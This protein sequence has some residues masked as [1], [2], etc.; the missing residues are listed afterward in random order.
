MIGM[1]VMKEDDLV[2]SVSEGGYGKRTKIEEYRR[3]SRGGFGIKNIQTSWVK[4][5]PDGA[6]ACLAAGA[7]DLGGT[8]MNESITRRYSKR[9]ADLSSPS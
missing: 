8:L 7:N 1:E 6:A 4:M 3:Q 9:L 2:M 5:G